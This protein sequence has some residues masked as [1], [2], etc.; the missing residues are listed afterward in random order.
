MI[1][2]EKLKMYAEKLFFRMND[3]EYE[4]LQQEF[5]VILKQM[6]IISKIDG[7]SEVT[8]MTFP[9]EK[10]GTQFREDV[11]NDTLSVEDVIKNSEDTSFEQVKV[12]KVVE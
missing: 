7:I 3:E 2:K 5:D 11:V 1:E 8:P 9:F 4:T 6:D 10:E 12:P